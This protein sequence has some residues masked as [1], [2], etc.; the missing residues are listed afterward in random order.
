MRVFLPT[1][2]GLLAW[3][4]LPL[5]AALLL[6]PVMSTLLT[7]LMILGGF[8]AFNALRR[9]QR[10]DAGKAA[11]VAAVAGLGGLALA[12]VPGAVG[13]AAGIGL[14]ALVVA[15]GL[16]TRLPRQAGMEVAGILALAGFGGLAAMAGGAEVLRTA[17]VM[18]VVA[19]WLVLGLWRMRGVVAQLVPQREPWAAGKGVSLTLGTLTG[20][21]AFAA[22]VP[23]LAAVPLL[24]L[25]RMRLH[26]PPRS[27]AELRRAGLVELSWALGAAAL[28]VSAS[29]YQ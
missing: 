20:I 29:G 14:G 10:R 3:V 18:A 1:E 24:Y 23:L 2:H 12:M 19:T 17:A 8:G 7:A 27:G 28:A 13:V 16:G 6:S 22:H 11:G 25:L 9:E 26:A 4:V 15:T 5:A 21:V